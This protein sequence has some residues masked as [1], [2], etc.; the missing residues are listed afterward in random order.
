MPLP[1]NWTPVAPGEII[2]AEHVNQGVTLVTFLASKRLDRTHILTDWAHLS[3]TVRFFF[4]AGGGVGEV[5]FARLPTLAP[6]NEARYR[7]FTWRRGPAATDRTAAVML[8][9]LGGVYE[10]TLPPGNVTLPASALHTAGI[11]ETVAAFPCN[12]GTHQL[13]V[14]YS[15]VSGTIGAEEYCELD[16]HFALPLVVQP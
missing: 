10:E 3:V 8:Y 11:A 13:G 16:L 15:V 14:G 9:T 12:P 1:L 4:A 6:Y 7:G 5:H 2:K